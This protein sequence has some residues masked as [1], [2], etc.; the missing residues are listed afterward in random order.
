MFVSGSQ[1]GSILLVDLDSG[2]SES[3]HAHN[4][5]SGGTSHCSLGPNGNIIVSGG[6]DGSIFVFTRPDFTILEENKEELADLG[7]FEVSNLETLP[8]GEDSNIKNFRILLEEADHRA[9][10]SQKEVIQTDMITTVNSIK[11]RLEELL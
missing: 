3:Y 4:Y 1:D 11:E 7:E 5:Q 9:K 10:Q 2:S 8:V 6:F